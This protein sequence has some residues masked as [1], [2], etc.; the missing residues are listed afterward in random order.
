LTCCTFCCTTKLSTQCGRSRV[1]CVQQRSGHSCGSMSGRQTS[2]INVR[3]VQLAVVCLVVAVGRCRA[4]LQHTCSSETLSQRPQGICGP[5]LSNLL[6][7]LCRSGYNKR[8]GPSTG[9]HRS[10][11]FL[12]RFPLFPSSFSSPLIFSP[13][14]PLREITPR[15]LESGFGERTKAVKLQRT[16]ILV[17]LKFPRS[18]N[19]KLQNLKSY[20]F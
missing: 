6:R 9:K 20:S 1:W 2:R 16:R 13:P 11:L 15:D 7:M 3:V 14:L 18:R 8:T 5:N 10:V 4:G 19:C 12:V 17:H